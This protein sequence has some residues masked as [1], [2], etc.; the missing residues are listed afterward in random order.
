MKLLN[1]LNLALLNVLGGAFDGLTPMNFDSIK[2]ALNVTWKGLV[3]IF[4][5][6]FIIILIVKLIQW[7]IV[8]ISTPPKDEE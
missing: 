6:I 4:A 5:V 1:T 2:V 7:A 8:K 3:A